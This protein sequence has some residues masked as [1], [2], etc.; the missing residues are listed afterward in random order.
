[1]RKRGRIR[2]EQNH[3]KVCANDE[4]QNVGGRKCVCVGGGGGGG[5]WRAAASI[6]IHL[7][8]SVK[9]LNERESNI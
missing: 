8:G 7:F 9:Y 2:S 5:V 3:G 6:S 4:I 1:M